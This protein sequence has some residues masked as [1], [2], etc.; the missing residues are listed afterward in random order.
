MATSSADDGAKL[1]SSTIG[2]SSEHQGVTKHALT[3]ANELARNLPTFPDTAPEAAPASLV[4]LPGKLAEQRKGWNPNL[5][6][7]NHER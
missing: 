3:G 7:L 4:S 5:Q 6:L 2:Q 1:A